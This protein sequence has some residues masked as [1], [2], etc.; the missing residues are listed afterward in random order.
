LLIDTRTGYVSGADKEWEARHGYKSGDTSPGELYNLK[1]DL[2]QKHNVAAEHPEK[3][4]ELKALLKKIR[5]QG[6]SAPR[7]AKP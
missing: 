4:A 7:L 1:T 6:H 5:E 2:S 3:V